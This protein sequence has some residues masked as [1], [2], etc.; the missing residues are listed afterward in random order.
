MRSGVWTLL[1]QLFGSQTGRL[2]S[3]HEA[4][5]GLRAAVEPLLRH[6]VHFSALSQPPVPG[7]HWYE[8][9]Y[10]LTEHSCVDV[11]RRVF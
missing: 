4:Q 5:R 11:A 3:E 1:Q 7:L 9:G 10:R 6:V 8:L 2:S